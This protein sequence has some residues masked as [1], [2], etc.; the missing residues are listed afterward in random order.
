MLKTRDILGFISGGPICDTGGQTEVR[1][2][3]AIG[4]SSGYRCSSGRTDGGVL[5][6]VSVEV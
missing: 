3:G 6:I 1:T 5:G 2:V 4:E